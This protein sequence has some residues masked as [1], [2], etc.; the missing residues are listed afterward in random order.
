MK[1]L[2][3]ALPLLLS[4]AAT[5]A[6]AQTSAQKSFDQFKSL[7]GSWE[8]KD[9]KGRPVGVSFRD[10]ARGSALMSEIQRKGADAV[11]I[12]MISMIHLDG[13][14]RPLLTH[15]CSI[16]SQSRMSATTSPDGKTIT[17]DFF[18]GTNLAPGYFRR[19]VFT[20]VDANHHTEEWNFIDQGKETKDWFDLHRSE[21]AQK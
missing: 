19:I 17:F 11:M 14:N 15:Y 16:G 8:G 2:R 21:V 1:S 18:D 3:I 10:T 4:F 9:S 7:A 12:S 5:A 13:P 20:I 6:F